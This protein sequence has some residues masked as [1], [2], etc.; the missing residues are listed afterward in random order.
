MRPA[1][2]FM[3]TAPAT[4]SAPVSSGQERT[5]PIGDD[6][7]GLALRDGAPIAEDRI[8]LLL[9]QRRPGRGFARGATALG[10]ALAA[11]VIAFVLTFPASVPS[12]RPPSEPTAASPET[13]DRPPA[14]SVATQ[15]AFPPTKPDSPEAG[16]P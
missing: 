9:P 16:A 12:S 14:P 15:P 2:N 10:L 3:R 11:A 13:A 8:V 1:F 4:N 5:G 7:R 6:D